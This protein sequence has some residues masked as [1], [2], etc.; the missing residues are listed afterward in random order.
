MTTGA[1]SSPIDTGTI[2]PKLLSTDALGEKRA[3]L[4]S[5]AAWPDERPPVCIETPRSLVFVT[6][7]LVYKL[8]KPL[9]LPSGDLRFLGP[10]A[11]ICAEDFRLNHRFAPDLYLGLV[12]LVRGIDGALV[13]GGHGRVVDWLLVMKR[14]PAAQMLDRRLAVGPT[15]H[16]DE[17]ADFGARLIR[18]YERQPG[19]LLAGL[20][21]HKHLR[22]NLASDAQ[23]LTMLLPHLGTFPLADLLAWSA[24]RLAF[25]APEIWMRAM[26]G[27]LRKGHGDLR[28][29]HVCLTDPP[30]AFHRVAVVPDDLLVDPYYE[31]TGLG[32]DAAK[33][34][35]EWIGPALLSQLTQTGFR[36]PSPRLLVLYAVLQCLAQARAAL[37]LSLVTTPSPQ[38]Q[39]LHQVRCRLAMAVRIA[40]NHS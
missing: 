20:V 22:T 7:H 31:I 8:K 32:L 34:G 2:D 12:P 29:R 5:G 10:R 15:P 38:T 33:S 16:W 6:Q 9:H 28:A 11:R 23:H 18:S 30:F 3:F 36:P 37:A 13:L 4:A 1:A 40:E 26:M 24:T 35:V 17:M 14:L 27:C 21:Y 39:D 25:A 19:G